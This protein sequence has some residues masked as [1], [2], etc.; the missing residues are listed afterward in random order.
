MGIDSQ[1]GIRI[2]RGS[3]WLSSNDRQDRDDSLQYGPVCFPS[4]FLSFF[5]SFMYALCESY[6]IFIDISMY[7]MYVY[8]CVFLK[9]EYRFLEN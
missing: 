1:S 7:C 2:P 6:Y 5:L 8:I 9:Y 3:F 4:F